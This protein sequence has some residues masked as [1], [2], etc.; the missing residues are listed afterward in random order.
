VSARAELDAVRTQL[1]GLGFKVAPGEDVSGHLVVLRSPIDGAVAE[2]RAILGASVSPGDALFRIVASSARLVLVRVPE[3]RAA[4]VVLGTKVRVRPREVTAG[5]GESSCGGVVERATGVVD[6]NRTVGV[7]V[8]LEEPCA[9]RV[10][11]RSLT[12]ELP[13]SGDTTTSEA[14]VLVPKAAVIDLRGK[15][16]VFVQEDDRPRFSWRAVRTGPNVG[17]SIVVED[18]LRE[19]ERVVVRG[20]VL[21]K[22]EVVRAEPLE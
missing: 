10:S 22:G 20:T 8:R 15:S 11:G 19:G 21:L 17:S 18:G 12:V 2:R 1:A 3:S 7:R 13:L 14:V 5:E 9:L 6:E 4:S 16:V